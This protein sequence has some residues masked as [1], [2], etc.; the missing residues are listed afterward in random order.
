MRLG[1]KGRG[2]LALVTFLGC[3]SAPRFSEMDADT[4]FQYAT[5]KLDA[6]KWD[7]AS[8][9]L[10]QFV[11][12]FP[13]DE[14][15]QEARYRLGEA[16]FGKGEYLIAASE[17]VRLA[18]DFPAGPWAERAR[19]EVCDSYFRLSPKPQLDQEYTDMA[20]DQCQAVLAY[21]PA[22]EHADSVRTMVATLQNKLAT[23]ELEAGQHYFKRGAYDSAIIYYDKVLASYP[24]SPAAPKA[25]F[26]LYRSYE[27]IGWTEE[28]SQTRER[29]LRDFPESDEARRVQSG[30]AVAP[31]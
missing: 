30:S 23:K 31:S 22:G 15:Y 25:L 5:E 26:G 28:A 29:L 8:R 18:S 20:I 7:D 21:Y 11:F 6:H 13:T 3:A 1:N 4:L 10:D 19:F 2:L 24:S 14:R 27:E 9:A 17:F 12:Q 16:H